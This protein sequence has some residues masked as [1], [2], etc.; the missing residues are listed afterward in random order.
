M[1]RKAVEEWM[2]RNEKEVAA[3]KRSD[4][5]AVG[6]QRARTGHAVIEE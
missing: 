1:D 2:N 6:N 4:W 3:M 5:R